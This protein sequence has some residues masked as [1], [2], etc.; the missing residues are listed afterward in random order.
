MHRE[1]AYLRNE[2]GQSSTSSF[3]AEDAT[4]SVINDAVLTIESVTVG[5]ERRD[6]SSS[7][8][9]AVSETSP[10][11]L[12]SLETTNQR[13][14]SDLGQSAL[15]VT[16]THAPTSSPVLARTRQGSVDDFAPAAIP[17]VPQQND[18]DSNE[19]D[20]MDDTVDILL[21]TDGGEFGLRAESWAVVEQTTSVEM[22]SIAAEMG[23][24]PDDSLPEV[25]VASE[26]KKNDPDVAEGN[27]SEAATIPSENTEKAPSEEAGIDKENPSPLD[28]ESTVEILSPAINAEQETI[29]SK[30]K[31]EAV[32]EN[33]QAGIEIERSQTWQH[34]QDEVREIQCHTATGHSRRMSIHMVWV[35]EPRS[36]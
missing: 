35:V 5:D 1:M 8:Y 6:S 10:D 21:P 15:Q 18:A 2:A 7:L 9:V 25:D 14:H 28:K 4:T 22:A 17:D 32:S 29:D 20:K 36:G 12:E 11:V 16:T 26:D 3:A 33:A 27:Q 23:S 34:Q 24:L 31:V 30:Q 13:R 19:S